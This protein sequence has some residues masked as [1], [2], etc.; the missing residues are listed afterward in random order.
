M[1]CV[2][3]D[4]MFHA[5]ARSCT[6]NYASIKNLINVQKCRLMSETDI[7][8]QLEWKHKA[9]CKFLETVNSCLLTPQSTQTQKVSRWSSGM[10]LT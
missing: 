9:N 8:N 7:R 6:R 1:M 2:R 10:C 4:F 5:C 3:G